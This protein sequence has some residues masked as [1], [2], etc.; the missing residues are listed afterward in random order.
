[1]RLDGNTSSLTIST[2]SQDSHP[3]IISELRDSTVLNTLTIDDHYSGAFI[4]MPFITITCGCYRLITFYQ[5]PWPSLRTALAMSVLKTEKVLFLDNILKLSKPSSQVV[6][7]R[8]LARPNG[9]NPWLWWWRH[10]IV[11]SKNMKNIKKNFT[12]FLWKIHHLQK[13]RSV[14]K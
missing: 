10:R 7:Q 6:L 4:R 2:V 5:F 8:F 9:H 13:C 14:K 12:F 1:M 11:S 3:S